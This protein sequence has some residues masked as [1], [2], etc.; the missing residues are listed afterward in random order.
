MHGESIGIGHSP[1]LACSY[2][3]VAGVL[4]ACAKLAAFSPKLPEPSH[5][6]VPEP[7]E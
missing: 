4:Y 1:V 5:H 7:A 2:L 6:A 3:M